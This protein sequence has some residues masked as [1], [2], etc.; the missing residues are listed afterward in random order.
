M[1]FIL[2]LIITTFFICSCSDS[3]NPVNQ[4]N[5]S[6]DSLVFSYDSLS[7]WSAVPLSN[8]YGKSFYDS[9]FSKVRM[10]FTGETDVD[11]AAVGI[12][13][14][15]QYGIFYSY[16]KLGMAQVNTDHTI[17]VDVSTYNYFCCNFTVAIISN[18]VGTH[19]VKIKWMKIFKT[20]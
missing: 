5:T 20:T 13:V 6:K 16:A 11:S 8:I 10:S 18:L 9:T 15:D 17:T 2:P 4:N 7:V 1:K 12:T 3:N 14:N 19:H